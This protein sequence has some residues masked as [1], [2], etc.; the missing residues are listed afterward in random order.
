MR[1]ALRASV[2]LAVVAGVLAGC[3]SNPQDSPATV[4]PAPAQ[5]VTAPSS[6]AA[7]P[8]PDADAHVD[9][10]DTPG[11]LEG[12][13]GALEDS[14]VES[15]EREDGSWLAQGSVSNTSDESVDYRIYASAMGDGGAST[16]GVVQVDVAGVAAGKTVEWEAAFPLE[17]EELT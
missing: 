8:T 9:V 13:V 15:F 7:E 16:R 3:T 10:D 6:S 11:S 17:D 5:S 1:N 14:R 2:T 12:L 4:E